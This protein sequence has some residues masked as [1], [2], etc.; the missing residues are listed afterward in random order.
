MVF[1]FGFFPA[2]QVTKSMAAVVLPCCGG[3]MIAI[4]GRLPAAKSV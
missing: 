1:R 4:F 2:T 3:D